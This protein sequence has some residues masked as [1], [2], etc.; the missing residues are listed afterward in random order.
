MITPFFNPPVPFTPPSGTLQQQQASCTIP[1][2]GPVQ[3]GSQEILPTQQ[4][5]LVLTD[6][7]RTDNLPGQLTDDD[8]R[9]IPVHI[10]SPETPGSYPIVV[11]SHGGGG[12]AD[13][14]SD[15]A[16]SLAEK[17]YVVIAPT[18]TGS[19]TEGI[20]AALQLERENIINGNTTFTEVITSTLNNWTESPDVRSD[21][22][23]DIS[24]VL[25]SLSDIQSQLPSQVT[26]DAESIAVM[27]HSTGAFTAMAIGGAN[28]ETSPSG[29]ITNARDPRV[30]AV[31]AI[32]P[33][34]PPLFGLTSEDAYS[35][36]KDIPTLSITSFQDKPGGNDWRRHLVAFK[37]MPN[38]GD[39]YQVVFNKFSHMGIVSDP[40]AVAAISGM[41][42]QFL[43]AQFAGTNMNVNELAE[44][45]DDIAY[46]FKK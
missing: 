44:F 25:D 46:L 12:S 5:N 20:K 13:S 4:A 35:N 42:D 30:D 37:T 34:P 21:R 40:S 41:T 33:P 6:S 7:T 14:V 38:Q 3:E 9:Q 19:D 16:Q 10:H 2:P 28:Y 32:S 45:S 8:G 11:L 31:I 18:H 15:L 26:M 29:A 24:F 39:D 1:E 36:V 23:A 27:G 43:E 22:P 17:G